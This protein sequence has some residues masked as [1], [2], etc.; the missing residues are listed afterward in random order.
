MADNQKPVLIK[1]NKKMAKAKELPVYF[2]GVTYIQTAKAYKIVGEGISLKKAMG[3]CSICGTIL[4]NP[5]SIKLGIGP[6]CADNMGIDILTGYTHEDVAT[7]MQK[8]KID[9]WFPKSCVT[10]SDT[11]DLNVPDI[12]VPKNKQTSKKEEKRLEIKE[13]LI[14]IY[15]AFDYSILTKVKALSGRRYHKEP[16]PHWN[17]PNIECNRIA[18]KAMGFDVPE[19]KN[20]TIEMPALPSHLQRTMFPYQKNGVKF[21]FEKNGRALIGD[22][23]GLGKTIQALAYIE[24][25]PDV[26]RALVICPAS[27]KLNWAAEAGKWL[28]NYDLY[29][30]NGK[31]A[32]VDIFQNSQ[33]VSSK[34]ATKKIVIINYDIMGAWLPLLKRMP[35]DVAVADEIHYL[36]NNKAKRT[37]AVV[38]IGKKVKGFIGL[39]G[40]P[41]VNRPIEFFNA[42][43]LINPG[44]FN[45]FWNYTKRYCNPKQTKWGWDY[46]GASNTAELH[47]M[48]NNIMIRRLKDDVL[49][50]LP[51]KIRSVVPMVLGNRPE[52]Q[53]AQDKVIEALNISIKEKISKI[54]KDKKLNKKQTEEAIRKAK[55][56]RN[57]EAML[58][59]EKLKQ[60]AV[61]GK[62]ASAI[63]WIETY[64]KTEDKL[65]VFCTHKSTIKLLQKAF[66][67][68]SVTIDGGVN[69]Q[70]R[71][72]AVQR[73][74]NDDTIKL[75][76]GNIKAAGVG[77]TLTAAHA[78]CFLEFDWVPAGHL[79]AEDRVHRIGQKAESV[80]AYYLTAVNT[81]DQDIM[82]MLE[83]KAKILDQVLDGKKIDKSSIFSKLLNKLRNPA[84]KKAA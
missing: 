68:N 1:L 5:N 60:V 81:I 77:L 63:D 23:M 19:Q 84:F 28:T 42:L 38:E 9:G 47:E 69:Q 33:I 24:T 80:H 45:S 12:I 72:E 13:H 14:D 22:E 49:P 8:I 36:K 30:L 15:F 48:V 56:A 50:D 57:A 10:L 79:Q 4:T 65:V 20:K 32:T 62:M 43:H 71:H 35:F 75:F 26:D 51:P 37:K 64:L 18:L 3:I 11:G 21:I 73:F 76:F 46:S 16:T 29:I 70:K 2:I 53:T 78:T 34:T 54:R 59:I 52:Y 55:M 40:T 27:L 17:C 66:P 83:D 31:T 41:I 74:Q 61:K 44:L 67:K 25:N 7:E 58:V 39:S 6:I 82:E